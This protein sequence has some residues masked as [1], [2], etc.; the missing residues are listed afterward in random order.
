MWECPWGRSIWGRQF[1]IEE[2]TEIYIESIYTLLK[3][4]QNNKTEVVDYLPLLHITL[5]TLGYARAM[6][7]MTPLPSELAIWLGVEIC[8]LKI[9]TV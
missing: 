3:V 4:H 6:E 1:C 5:E 7:N 9:N 2:V 8:K